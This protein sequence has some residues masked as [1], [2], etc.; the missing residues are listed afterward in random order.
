MIKGLRFRLTLLF[1]SLSFVA[2]LITTFV[3]GFLL[4][5]QLTQAIDFEL[6]EIIAENLPNVRHKGEE[7]TLLTTAPTVSTKPIRV[8]ASI[9]LYDANERLLRKSGGPGVAKFYDNTLEITK[10]DHSFRSKSRPLYVDGKL[11][12]Y[13]QV[14]ISTEHREDAERERFFIL[15]VTSPIL[16]C[17]LFASG[18]Y[19]TTLTTKPIEEAFSVLR[20]F[21]INAGHE[22][23]TPLSVAQAVLDNLDHHPQK[24]DE[25]VPK[26]IVIGDSLLR[27]RNLVDDLM[28]L[29]KLDADNAMRQPFQ[30]LPLHEL[31]TQSVEQLQNITDGDISIDVKSLHHAWI[32]GN[33]QHIQQM[34][35]NLLNNAISYNKPN[36]TVSIDLRVI[37]DKAVLT[38]SD[39]GI[40]IAKEELPRIFDRFYRVE[41]SR[42]RQTGGSG[43]G[44]AIVKA[45]VDAHNG[46]VDVKSQ[47]DS[48]TEFTISLP[49][50]TRPSNFPT[51]HISPTDHC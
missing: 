51:P 48:G 28:I 5:I 30:A 33:H 23:N 42:S 3:T 17:L 4:H 21:M 20:T 1:A 26:F 11:V 40:G 22:L 32:R 7:L 6:T 47:V 2:Y 18:Y 36:G 41:G 15:L 50:V 9:Q 8:L 46:S 45:V 44:L 12:G 35:T 37:G 43:L 25:F 24:P 16:L 19:F 13:L 29:A 34:L 14:Q 39:T 31:V 49:T 27:M 38:I 10:E